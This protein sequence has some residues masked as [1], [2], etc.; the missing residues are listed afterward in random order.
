MACISSI[1]IC[2]GQRLVSNLYAIFAFHAAFVQN[3]FTS[4]Y[5]LFGREKRGRTR[6]VKKEE[7]VPVSDRLEGNVA[8]RAWSAD[9]SNL[10]ADSWNTSVG[11]HSCAQWCCRHDMCRHYKISVVCRSS[12]RWPLVLPINC[13]QS[14][15]PH[16]E[17]GWNSIAIFQNSLR[18]LCFGIT[19]H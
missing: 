18:K 2:S 17:Q 8:Q 5:P 15:Q 10:G 13:C 1:L 3:R 16:I 14:H 4:I 6:L 9:Q 7:S 11:C 12:G 19:M